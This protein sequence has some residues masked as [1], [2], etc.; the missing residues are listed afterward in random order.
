MKDDYS[1]ILNKS[2]LVNDYFQTHL[3]SSANGTQDNSTLRDI[4]NSKLLVINDKNELLNNIDALYLKRNNLYQN[5][6][7][8]LLA[9]YY[10]ERINENVNS[11]IK[12]KTIS[13]ISSTQKNRFNQII[14]DLFNFSYLNNNNITHPVLLQAKNEAKE[15][16]EY[17]NKIKKNLGYETIDYSIDTNKNVSLTNLS[18]IIMSFDDKSRHISGSYNITNRHL[19][20]TKASTTSQPS[21]S[22]TVSNNV[23]Y[24]EN[25]TS[26]Y[27]YIIRSKDDFK[28]VRGNDKC[29]LITCDLTF[30]VREY[31]NLDDYT[32]YNGCKD[33]AITI[34]IKPNW[35]LFSR[36][37]LDDLYINQSIAGDII[38]RAASLPFES[39]YMSYGAN[40][41]PNNSNK[42]PNIA[43]YNVYNS[44]KQPINFILVGPGHLPN[45]NIATPPTI[46]YQNASNVNIT[47]E[48][49]RISKASTSTGIEDNDN[50]FNNIIEEEL[51]GEKNLS[52][53]ARQNETFTEEI[54]ISKIL[55]SS[56][57]IDSENKLDIS[58]LSY[59][60]NNGNLFYPFG[61]V[62]LKLSKNNS[63]NIND[64]DLNEQLLYIKKLFQIYSIVDYSTDNIIDNTKMYKSLYQ[65]Y[66]FNI[67]SQISDNNEI[68][69]N[70]QD[71]NLKTISNAISTYYYIEGQRASEDPYYNNDYSSDITTSFISL[72]ETFE[73]IPNLRTTENADIDTIFS[74]AKASLTEL[75]LEINNNI[76]TILSLLLKI[77][78]EIENQYLLIKSDV[79]RGKELEK[80]LDTYESIIDNLTDSESSI[81]FT[82]FLLD[83]KNFSEWKV[84]YS[85]YSDDGYYGMIPLY[86]MCTI[87]L[88][89]LTNSNI[90]RYLRKNIHQIIS[91]EN[92]ENLIQ[93]SEKLKSYNLKIKLNE[94][95]S[96][97]KIPPILTKL[98]PSLKILNTT[99][100]KKII[101][102]IDISELDSK[103]DS[104]S[105]SKYI[106]FSIYDCYRLY[107][108]DEKKNLND[109][110]NNIKYYNFKCIFCYYQYLKVKYAIEKD[111][112]INKTINN[113]ILDIKNYITL[114]KDVFNS[115]ENDNDNFIKKF[116]GEDYIDFLEGNNG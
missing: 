6:L 69:K 75:M 31:N 82:P 104:Y 91:K 107:S 63:N 3:I 32:F 57:T 40:F 85:S 84:K 20:L 26:E 100:F 22:D 72:S 30:K 108:T 16:L 88:K 93:S 17:I 1:N 101:K 70:L 113:I 80:M 66:F 112:N 83:I 111:E 33:K 36:D 114:W 21:G 54:S 60:D 38:F 115:E 5:L 48:R 61:G 77:T 76:T 13:D 23:I 59:T 98:I 8:Y 42:Y 71:E 18:D 64:S 9:E 79:L 12:Y 28:K 74:E 4:Y 14:E 34:T 37:A 65:S 56:F 96:Y 116:G 87:G 106:Q 67:D 2:K 25:G 109:I 102:S 39:I 53:T 50:N 15:L 89:H 78:E 41:V 51:K 24:K 55:D 95:I 68:F 35:H 94:Y 44:N 97:E 11:Y 10:S 73:S 86:L 47:K 62:I 81:T 105:I 19:K 27:P 110:F 7:S 90:R 103:I 92:K 52:G 99:D 58:N 29:C 43:F 49:F 46:Y 45:K